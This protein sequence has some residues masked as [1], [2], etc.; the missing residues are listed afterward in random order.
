MFVQH[1]PRT[2]SEGAV[3]E[4]DRGHPVAK[5]KSNNTIKS[6]Q[7]S[8]CFIYTHYEERK[9]NKKIIIRTIK[10]SKNTQGLVILFEH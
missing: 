6:C 9:N 7:V 4:E 5:V 1:F 10:T 3:G 2:Q 8:L